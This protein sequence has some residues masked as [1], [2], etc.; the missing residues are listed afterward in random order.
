MPDP[1]LD[2]QPKPFGLAVTTDVTNSIS[3]SAA[4]KRMSSKGE[5]TSLE[6]VRAVDEHA[7][8]VEYLLES[9]STYMRFGDRYIFFRDVSFLALVCLWSFS[10]SFQATFLSPP[11][12]I[13]EDA[14]LI[15]M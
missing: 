1:D 14:L 6:L 11:L 5:T 4:D 9:S 2:T 8:T 13:F 15:N 12:F 7:K 10:F 3:T